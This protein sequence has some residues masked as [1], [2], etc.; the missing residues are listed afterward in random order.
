MVCTRRICTIYA[1]ALPARKIFRNDEDEDDV[2]IRIRRYILSDNRF[3]VSFRFSPLCEIFIKK[4]IPF[5]FLVKKRLHSSGTCSC[6]TKSAGR[7]SKNESRFTF[8]SIFMDRF[9]PDATLHIFRSLSIYIYIF[10][11]TSS[12]TFRWYIY[13]VNFDLAIRSRVQNEPIRKIVYSIRS[14]LRDFFIVSL[15][16]STVLRWAII[17]F[18][19]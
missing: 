2:V 16:V 14:L 19:K 12:N 3:L 9:W 15:R 4:I 5:P 7:S 17:F 6:R 11:N 1:V 13:C 8:Y 18:Q 10:I